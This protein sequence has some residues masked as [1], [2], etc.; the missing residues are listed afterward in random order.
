MMVDTLST[1][2]QEAKQFYDRLLLDRAEVAQVFYEAGQMRNL[3]RNQGNQISWRRFDSL[4]VNTS[5]LSEG[6][7]PSATSISMTEVTATV[8]QYG[9]YCTISDMLD[10]TAIDH[11][12]EELIEVLGQQAGESIEAVIQDVIEAGTSVI[13]ATGSGREDQVA[14]SPLTVAMVRKAARTLDA[15]NT[16]RFHGPKQN[17][18]VGAGHYLGFIHPRMV[19]DL[20]SDSEFQNA[21]QYG[22]HDKL[23]K[24]ELFEIEG[25]R[26]IQTTL[27]PVFAGAG[28]GGADVY[29]MIVCGQ[30]AFGVVDVA[31][32]GKFQSIVKQ[33]GSAGTDDPLDQRAT[34]GWKSLFVSKIL[35][36]NFM[37]RLE[38]GV[39]A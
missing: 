37:T 24:G 30:H 10:M 8:A 4:S 26:I 6:V 2:T 18:V 27:A 39:S 17:K 35:N 19:Y 13:Y 22:D 20:K 21:V 3:P 11:V 15:N 38:A 7:T 25:V 28:N 16:Q 12:V 36:N 32:T 1:L 31:G 34:V 14:N 29:G 23:Y 9:A 33:L 5:T